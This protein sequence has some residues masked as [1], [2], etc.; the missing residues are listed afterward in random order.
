MGMEEF[1]EHLT[2]KVDSLTAAGPGYG[3]PELAGDLGVI[4]RFAE[5]A[6][7]AC[8]Q[9]T[10]QQHQQQRQRSRSSAGAPAL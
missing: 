2:V 6:L 5:A 1:L 8:E 9:H 3:P 10:S 4:R 7:K